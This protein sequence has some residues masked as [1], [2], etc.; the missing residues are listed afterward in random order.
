MGNLKGR[1]QAELEWLVTDL[2]GG[3]AMGTPTGVRTRKYHSFYSTISGRSQQS[4]LI[5][6]ELKIDGHS[7][8]PHAYS[9]RASSGAS[10]DV[11]IHPAGEFLREFRCDPYPSWVWQV[12][13]GNKVEFSITPVLGR[14]LQFNFKKIG[15]TKG[16][17]VQLRPFFAMRNL[18]GTG[19]SEWSLESGTE[20]FRVTSAKG[21][22]GPSSLIKTQGQWSWKADPSWY[23]QFHYTEEKAR[24]YDYE[25]DL[26][27]AGEF[28]LLLNSDSSFMLTEIP[29]E[30]TTGQAQTQETQDIPS[31]FAGVDF[32]P[33]RDFILFNP[34]GIV[35]GYPWF[36][37]WGRD[38]FISLPGIVAS[39]LENGGDPEKVYAWSSDLLE[40]WGC[41][42]E[43]AGRLPNLIEKD[44]THQW[45]SA[46]ATLWWIHSLTS[47]WTYSL[48]P[49]PIFERLKDRFAKYLDAAISSIQSGKHSFLY[50]MPNGLLEMTEPHA[51]W[52]DA[53]VH[54][55]AVTPR[56]GMLP[57]M[58]AL[59]CQALALQS[60]WK[61][62]RVDETLRPTF[63]N[64]LNQTQEFERPNRV[65]LFSLPLAPGFVLQDDEAL[66]E[67][68]VVTERDLT[69]PV[70]LR[71][72]KPSNPQYRPHYRGNQTERDQAYHQGAVWAWLGGH[73]LMARTRLK[74]KAPKNLTEILSPQSMKLMPIS[75]HIAEIFNAE[76]PFQHQGA[77]AQ[78]WS[79]ACLE[80]Y[81]ARKKYKLDQ[82]LL[83]IIQT[84]FKQKRVNRAKSAKSDKRPVEPGIDERS[85]PRIDES[86]R[87]RVAKE[88]VE[89]RADPTNPRPLDF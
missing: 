33:L 76:S 2:R 7:V 11:V 59:W 19:G 49:Y 5:D 26:F 43:S 74:T 42:I 21:A 27:S 55:H 66:L 63:Q 20:G 50:L 46:D 83:E 57:E 54:G 89:G 34:P 36:G 75:G 17:L 81:R 47:L 4:F 79:L 68:V 12:P 45:E 10:S 6:F 44:G 30:V 62:G 67:A 69:T 86:R 41:W 73:Q 72:L 13:T 38:T 61:S 23:H 14:G 82:P 40:R 70:G 53:R 84:T 29:E 16:A 64:A 48:G 87:D 60:V 58:N 9:A 31:Y 56:C 78:A 8:W 24:G 1:L 3:F 51:T 39:W 15:K 37:E 65:F 88:N 28:S 77:P 80:E 22:I 25:E 35:A 85:D 52:M 32:F 71:T 18:H